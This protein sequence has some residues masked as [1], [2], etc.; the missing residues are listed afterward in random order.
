MVSLKSVWTYFLK[1]CCYLLLEC[2][3]LDDV[4]C[5]RATP[6][7]RPAA[8]VER[9]QQADSADPVVASDHDGS[10]GCHRRPQA[11]DVDGCSRDG[12]AGD[13]V[14]HGGVGMG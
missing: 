2:D 8:V 6:A 7:G 1:L 10:D 4:L 9:Q 3:R 12:G 5:P 14:D 11:G 13:A